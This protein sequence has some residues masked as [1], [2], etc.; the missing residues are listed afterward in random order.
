MGAGDDC[1]FGPPT[2]DQ[3]LEGAPELRGS[4]D[5]CPSDLA[6]RGADLAIAGC[7]FAAFALAG[8]FVVART[9]TGPLGESVGGTESGHVDTDFHQELA[10]VAP[11]TLS[12]LHRRLPGPQGQT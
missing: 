4:S 2:N 3:A 5:R 9:H 7:G 10:A 12:R 1:P 6:Q 11:N 8:R